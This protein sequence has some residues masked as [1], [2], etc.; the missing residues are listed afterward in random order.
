[1]LDVTLLFGKENLVVGDDEAEVAGASKIRPLI[2]DLVENAV[3]EREPG[4]AHCRQGAPVLALE[5][6]RGSMPGQP[7]ASQAKL[8]PAAPIAETELRFSAEILATRV[9]YRSQ[10]YPAQRLS[11]SLVRARR[12][13]DQNDLYPQDQPLSIRPSTT[14]QAR[15]IGDR[16]LIEK[17]LILVKSHAFFR[18]LLLCFFVLRELLEAH[19]VEDIWRLSELN[20]VVA[21][22]LDTIAPRVAEIEKAAI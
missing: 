16:E 2:I 19:A 20:I 5:V 3:A 14:Y 10:Q 9:F 22:D 13:V 12:T 1:M 15:L 8:K 21:Y 6:Q 11:L 18:K 4:A 7:D 17:Q